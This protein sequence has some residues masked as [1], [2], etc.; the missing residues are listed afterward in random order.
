[1]RWGP[2]EAG[3]RIAARGH[4]RH[5]R[6]AAQ[7]RR[8]VLLHGERRARA[9]EAVSKAVVATRGSGGRSRFLGEAKGR[10]NPDC[11]FYILFLSF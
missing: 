8:A 11:L 9:S 7:T 6:S 10:S 3:G 5:R 2:S 1:M 4:E